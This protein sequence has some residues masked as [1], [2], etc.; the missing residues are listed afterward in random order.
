L[1]SA[2]EPKSTSRRTRRHAANAADRN[3]AS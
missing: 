1:V 2:P 3:H